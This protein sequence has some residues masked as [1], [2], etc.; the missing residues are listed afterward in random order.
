MEWT[1]VT[2]VIALAGLII[3]II[4]PIIRLN[5]VITQ[6]ST[7]VETLGKS[8]ETLTSKNSETHER[9]WDKL[10]EHEG[11]LSEHD[12]RIALIERF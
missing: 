7:V 5:T 2:V 6:L 1:I 12:K 10:G 3:A 9:L 4:K 11:T 8:L